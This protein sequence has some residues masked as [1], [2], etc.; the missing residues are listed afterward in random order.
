ML[1]PVPLEYPSIVRSVEYLIDSCVECDS[2]TS[3]PEP[4]ELLS[5]FKEFF[6]LI[7]FLC[8]ILKLLLDVHQRQ[9]DPLPLL[10][11]HPQWG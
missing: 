1:H 4:Q 11:L 6:K 3:A 8:V 9:N 2:V 5:R 10:Q 7:I